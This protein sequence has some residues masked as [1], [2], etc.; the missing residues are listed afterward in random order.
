MVVLVSYKSFEF[1]IGF[2][3]CY[4]NV[5]FFCIGFY[6][7]GKVIGICFVIVVVYFIF[8]WWIVIYFWIDVFRSCVINCF[9][10]RIMFIVY[11]GIWICK[12]ID[13][14]WKLSRKV[15]GYIIDYW[16]GG[17]V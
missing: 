16:E 1:I 9:I 5:Y 6:M 10:M 7:Y 2:E 12:L 8:F 17:G 13:N 15:I 3:I 4:R 11:F 14:I